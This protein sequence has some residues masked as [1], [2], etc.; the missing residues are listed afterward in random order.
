VSDSNLTP[1]S[2]DVDRDER[3][4]RLGQR[5]LTVWLTGLSGSGKS[6]LAHAAERR[7][8]DQGRAVYVLDGD[9][10]R[11]GLC[12]D[13]GFGPEARRENIRRV[14]EVARL[15]NDAGLIVLASFIA[16]YREDRAAAR[17]VL[18]AERWFE[19]HVATPIDECRRRDP[20][21]LYARADA[22]ELAQFT[23]VS[24]PYEEPSQPDLR[25]DTAG[26]DLPACVESLLAAIAPRVA[27]GS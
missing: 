15:M 24:A 2:G 16:P 25:L 27:L 21:G 23:G 26:R 10:V 7:L 4:R 13:L 1:T 19:V 9:N 12:R 11:G 22:G 6:T 5:G 14:A 20:K 8:V 18:S 3:E 17:A